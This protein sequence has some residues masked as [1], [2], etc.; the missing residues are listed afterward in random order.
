VVSRIHQT[1]RI[2]YL[3]VSIHC[4]LL[5]FYFLPHSYTIFLFSLFFRFTFQDVILPRVLDDATL[6]SLNT[7]IHTNNASVSV[8][9]FP[10]CWYSYK[11]TPF[12]NYDILIWLQVISLLKDDTLFIRELF[13][14]M[15]SSD[16]SME[17]KREL[18]RHYSFS[19]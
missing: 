1:Y 5:A 13:A 16:I 11:S 18:V 8:L 10:K 14:K 4:Y 9:A 6:A 12:F 2:G 17:S 3:K 19:C 7:M 15:R